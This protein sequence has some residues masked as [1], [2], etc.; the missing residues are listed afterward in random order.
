MR[1]IKQ[2][3]LESEEIKD[4][5]FATNLYR[6]FCNQAWYDYISDDVISF[7][8]RAAGSFIAETRNEV[9]K[10][11]KEDYMDFYCSDKEGIII[12]E[13]KS[14]LYKN[15]IILFEEFYALDMKNEKL[16]EKQIKKFKLSCPERIQYLRENNLK[17]ILK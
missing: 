16:Y 12:E 1:R 3:L 7:S 13:I 8:W 6:N 4:L 11:E 14:F 15:G 9:F 5:E 17:E 10:V 2:I